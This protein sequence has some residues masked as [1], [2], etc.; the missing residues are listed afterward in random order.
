MNGIITISEKRVMLLMIDTLMDSALQ[1]ALNSGNV[2]AFQF[3]WKVVVI[4]LM[5]S[6]RF[7]PCLLTWIVHY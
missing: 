6:V 3:L 5:L 7:Q 1:A 2:P 4:I